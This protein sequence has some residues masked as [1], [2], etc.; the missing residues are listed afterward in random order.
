[1]KLNSKDA[2][3]IT[4]PCD[5]YLIKVVGD[6]HP[7]YKVFVAEVLV[8]Y[9]ETVTVERFEERPSRNGNFVSLNIR[10]RIEEEIHLTRLFEE[11]K[12]NRMVKMVL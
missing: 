10:M 1:M 11:L 3:K 2:P 5:N 9:D 4:F 7:D 6:S 8:K 12:G